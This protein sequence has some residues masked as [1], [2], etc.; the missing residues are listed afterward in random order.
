MVYKQDIINQGPLVLGQKP[1]RDLT[2]HIDRLAHTF[3]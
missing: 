1:A 2:V 3:R